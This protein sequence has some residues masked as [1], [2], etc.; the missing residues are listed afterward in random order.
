[1][2]DGGRQLHETGLANRFVQ[3]A[4]EEAARCGASRVKVVGAKVGALQA[5]DVDHLVEDFAALVRGTAL[6][7]ARLVV[8]R[9]PATAVCPACGASVP[10]EA[11]EALCPDC[12]KT[13]LETATGL[14]LSL[15]WLDVE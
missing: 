13:K 2:R 7:G 8:E 3:A 9:P 14:E 6:D 12:G 15:A 10:G 5:V 4:F 11:G 1:M